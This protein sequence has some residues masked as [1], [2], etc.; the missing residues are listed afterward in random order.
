MRKNERRGPGIE[1]VTDSGGP[2]L[3][4]PE[5][6][7]WEGGAPHTKE[8]ILD[9]PARMTARRVAIRNRGFASGL[10]SNVGK[11]SVQGIKIAS[12]DGNLA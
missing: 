4:S 5:D 12:P 6:A 1:T 7:A 8:A 9:S 3:A 11:R 2:T 10:A